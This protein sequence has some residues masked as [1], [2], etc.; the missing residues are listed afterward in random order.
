MDFAAA[1]ELCAP[2]M[3]TE[4]L[5][6]IASVESGFNPLAIGVVGGRLQRQPQS[7][8]EAL[9]T[10]KMLADSGWN[11]SVGLIQ[12]NQSNFAKYRITREAAF[13]LCT[14]LRVGNLI[15]QDC[16]KR[17]GASPTAFGDALSCYYSGNFTAGYRLGYVERVLKAA[18]SSSDTAVAPIP[19][20]ATR[21]RSAKTQAKPRASS[22]SL[23]VSAPSAPAKTAATSD[24]SA[25]SKG[26]DTA[27]LF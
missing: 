12:I 5:R 19:V 21:T 17:A 6:Q 7:K 18:S 13:D 23:F 4:T 25:T 15:F 22:Q 2:G 26:P 3:Q 10:A 14:N 9:A 11:Y 24:G 1:A 27:L 20:I 16:L 8:A